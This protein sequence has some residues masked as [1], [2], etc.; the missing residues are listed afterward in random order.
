MTLVNPTQVIP[1]SEIL[2]S[3]V[4]TP[5]NQLANVINGNLDGDNIKDDGIPAGKLADG[6]VTSTPPAD[7]S[8]VK[9]IYWKGTAGGFVVS[10]SGT[11]V[12]AKRVLTWSA[13]NPNIIALDTLM[14]YFGVSVSEIRNQFIDA[15]NNS[16]MLSILVNTFYSNGYQQT[17]GACYVNPGETNLNVYWSVGAAINDGILTL[18]WEYE[19]LET[20]ASKTLT[21]AT[22]IVS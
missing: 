21:G 6:A 1:E 9:A 7:L 18:E 11:K 15:S 16:M 17:A 12:T 4:N 20:L 10:I 14:S 2:S 3:D 22:Y 5:I 19:S 8:T 13:S